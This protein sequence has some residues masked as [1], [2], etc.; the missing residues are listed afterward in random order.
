[1]KSFYSPTPRRKVETTQHINKKEKG[2]PYLEIWIVCALL[3]S[4][5]VNS[6]KTRFG[7]SP[8][9]GYAYLRCNTGLA[10]RTIQPQYSD[11]GSKL[12]L[13]LTQATQLT[14]TPVLVEIGS[15]VQAENI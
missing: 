14:E 6:N 12:E 1:M 8:Q 10:T 13:E 15:A 5:V 7:L 3:F 11:L 4:R 2:V 9:F